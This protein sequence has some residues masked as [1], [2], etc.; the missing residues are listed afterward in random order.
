M[1]TRSGWQHPVW[2]C[3]TLTLTRFKNRGLAGSMLSGTA[4][5]TP[6]PDSRPEVWLEACCLQ[7]HYTQPDQMSGCKHA[8]WNCITHTQAGLQTRGLAG[9][10][11]SAT[12]LHIHPDQSSGWKHAVCNC[13]THT[14]T[15]SLAGSMLSATALHTPSPRLD[16]RP[17]VW[18]EACCLELLYTQPYQI[19]DGLAGTML[20]GTAIYTLRLDSQT[21]AQETPQ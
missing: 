1:D 7:L 11:L 4:L 9:S 13:T 21:V 12:A 2:N 10:M 14:Q 8:V 19:P 15:T 6:R 16:S 20:P 3:S 17:E 5:H 18:L